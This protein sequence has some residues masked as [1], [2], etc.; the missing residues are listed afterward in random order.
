MDRLLGQVVSRA[1]RRGIRGEP[2]WLAVGVGAWLWRRAR[3]PASRPIWKGRVEPGQQLLVTMRDP[4]AK[5]VTER[6]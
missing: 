1:L 2:L 5:T 3:N 4:R 6:A